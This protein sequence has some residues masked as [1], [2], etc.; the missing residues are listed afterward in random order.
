MTLIAVA[1]NVNRSQVI[2]KISVEPALCRFPKFCTKR[3]RSQGCNYDC[4]KAMNA[5]A[6]VVQFAS[7][8]QIE[9]GAAELIA[10][11]CKLPEITRLMHGMPPS[12]LSLPGYIDNVSRDYGDIGSVLSSPSGVERIQRESSLKHAGCR[13]PRVAASGDASAC[14]WSF[15]HQH[16]FAMVMARSP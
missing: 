9:T 14:G 10:P 12:D 16:G 4:W 8:V 2:Q 6:D 1:K 3:Q 13:G 7:R 11:G 5:I 15:R